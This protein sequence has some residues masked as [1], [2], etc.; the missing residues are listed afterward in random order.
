MGRSPQGGEMKRI[1]MILIL[2]GCTSVSGLKSTP[3]SG[4][5]VET[6]KELEEVVRISLEALL[7]IG[8]EIQTN[9]QISEGEVVIVGL[10]RISLMT[11]GELIKIHIQTEGGKI[12][13][14]VDGHSR[15][16]T[17]ITGTLRAQKY[18]KNIIN[19]LEGSL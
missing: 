13:V 18:E 10:K 3:A 6:S 19:Y 17:Q 9:E 12:L 5:K 1:L 2:T 15:D 8:M 16:K 7:D 14:Y 4:Q 11:N